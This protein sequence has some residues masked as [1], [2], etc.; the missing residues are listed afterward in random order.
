MKVHIHCWMLVVTWPGTCASAPRKTT[1]MAIKGAALRRPSRTVVGGRSD[2]WYSS[3]PAK[4]P[5]II[6]CV[7]KRR[8]KEGLKKEARAF[9]R[10]GAS[11]RPDEHLGG[12]KRAS[13]RF[14][15]STSK[16]DGCSQDLKVS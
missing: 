12:G 7:R 14:K 4:T 9:E 2:F 3:V 15:N 10:S 1:R 16:P 8:V 13:G 6:T 5:R 11:E